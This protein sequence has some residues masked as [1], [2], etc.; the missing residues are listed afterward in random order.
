MEVTDITDNSIT[1]TMTEGG[2]EH[3]LGRL[4]PVV[5]QEAF[6][7][8]NILKM[9]D[10][11]YEMENYIKQKAKCAKA[12]T[13]YISDLYSADEKCSELNPADFEVYYTEKMKKKALEAIKEIDSVGCSK[14]LK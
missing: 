7:V 13:I 8:L 1:V 5:E 11:N 4:H 12:N 9:R 2:I 6:E 10:V 3:D 14:H